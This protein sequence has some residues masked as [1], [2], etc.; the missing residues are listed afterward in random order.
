[1]NYDMRKNHKDGEKK[2][3]NSVD[4]GENVDVDVDSSLVTN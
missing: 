4:A 2:R 1:M 3:N